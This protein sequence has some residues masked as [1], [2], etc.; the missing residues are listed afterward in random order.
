M[1]E[2][3]MVKWMK[4]S[5]RCTTVA[6][7]VLCGA[8]VLC[9]GCQTPKQYHAEADKVAYGII[10]QG[11]KAA[12]GKTEPFS[13]ERP[14][15]ILRRRLLVGQQLPV[16]GQASYG[17][18]EL[19]PIKLWPEPK[20]PNTTGSSDLAIG[21]HGGEAV[22]LTL[23]DA[24]AVGARNSSAYQTQK[25]QV[26]GA[27]LSLDQVRHDFGN[28]VNSS[29]SALAQSDKSSGSTVNGADYG[30]GIGWSRQLENGMQ[31][32]S[33]FATDLAVLLTGGHPSS[34]GQTADASIKIPLLRG[35]GVA[36]AREP[37]TQAE[38]NVLYAVWNFE[39][40]KQDFAVSIASGYLG[41]LRQ[42]DQV[43]NSEENYKALITSTR[44]IKRLAEAGMLPQIQVDQAVQ[45][46][47]NA[48][49]NWVLAQQGYYNRIDDFKVVLGLPT[50]ANVVLDRSELTRLDEQYRNSLI[51]TIVIDPNA[52]V[53]PA[54][55]PVILRA[56]GGEKAGPLEMD[57]EEAVR[58]A[59]KHRND[60]LVSMGEVFDNQRQV[61]VAADQLR[62][63]LT[64]LGTAR[65][66]EARGIG[67][68]T[69]PDAQLRLDR[70]R[71]NA[72]LTLDLPIDRQ[73]ERDNYRAA[74]VN[75]EQ[76]V[77]SQQSLEDTIKQDVR[78]SLRDLL[79][80]RETVQIQALAVKLAEQRVRSTNLFLQAGRAQV[81][82]LLDAQ[83]SLLSSQNALTAAFVAY[84]VAELQLQRNMGVLAVNEEGLW[85]EYRPGDPNDTGK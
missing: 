80:A 85:R 15:D 52:P 54:D 48:R 60:L 20:D 70:G 74:I 22:K 58:I 38:R 51:E 16:A 24:L 21:V 10:R 30:A 5:S 61:V 77:R 46:E 84:R 2:R 79:D 66:G 62:A 53:P 83:N 4:I 45:D 35:A 3:L 7:V 65:V 32:Q 14:S 39:K 23:L 36:I 82:D 11:Q 67:G 47:L 6:V 56:A 19:D 34:L 42:M 76:A 73:I 31:L 26:F 55:A 64:F 69:E 1:I 68:A 72:L 28:Q 44:R 29:L 81:R 50:D 8:I 18:D 59:L 13:I 27:A 49:N 71:Y 43:V 12:L 41:V 57:P 25:E 75:F 17:S 33:A 63:E 37:L 78:G 40:Y 9:A